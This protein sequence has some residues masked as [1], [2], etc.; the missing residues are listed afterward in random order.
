MFSS[1]AGGSVRHAV[2]GRA[3]SREADERAGFDHR[4]MMREALAFARR[5]P[6]ISIGAVVLFF[7]G[8]SVAAAR[9]YLGPV[10]AQAIAHLQPAPAS[11]TADAANRPA[12][13]HTFARIDPANVDPLYLQMLFAFEDRRFYW[14]FGIDPVGIVRAVRDLVVKQRIVTGGSTL[15]MQVARLIDNDYSRSPRMKLRQI[16]RAIQLEAT[17]SKKEILSLYL[18]LAPF[19]GKVKGVRAATLKFFG[20]EPGRLSTAEAALLVALPQAPE[21]RRV[22]RRAAAARRAR[23]FVLRTVA[24]AGVLTPEEARTAALEPLLAERPPMPVTKPA[25]RPTHTQIAGLFSGLA[26]GM[27]IVA[28]AALAD[29]VQPAVKHDYFLAS[30]D[31]LPLDVRRRL[32]APLPKDTHQDDRDALW[33]F[34]ASRREPVWVERTGWTP[35]ARAMIEEL[36]RADDWGLD[37]GEFQVP[38]LPAAEF[39]RI[40]LSDE[41]LVDA[42]MALSLAALKYAR[43]ARGGRIDDPATQ[44]SS[45]LDRKPQVKSPYLV[46][47][48]LAAAEAP[49]DFLRKMHPQHPQFERLRQRYLAI[50]DGH[51]VEQIE[52]PRGSMI[53]PG[54]THDDIA[55]IRQ[56]LRAPAKHPEDE[57]RYDDKLVEAVKSFQQKRGLRQDGLIGSNTRRAFNE[58]TKVSLP[59]LLANMEQ[60]R[61][62]PEDLGEAYVWVNIP[63]YQVRVVKD[64]DMLHSERVIVGELSKQTPIFSQDM[65][66]IYFHP[67]WN[68]PQSIKI[69]QVLP[70]L[71]RG[72][73]YFYKQGFRLVRNGREIR[74]GSV[75]WS[76]A[77]IRNYDVY[78]PSG[79]YNALG[80][81]KFTFPNKHAVYLHDTQTKGLFTSSQPTFSHGC[82]RVRNPLVLAQLLLNIDKNWSAEEVEQMLK[83]KPDEVAVYLD[84]HIPVHLTYFTAQVD[85]NGDVTTSKDVYGHEKRI[86]QALNGQWKS[87][88]KGADHL[89]QVELA[90]R[91]DNSAK[92]SKSRNR[93]AS[94]KSSGGGAKR[95]ASRRGGGSS[96]NYSRVSG[97][98]NSANDVFRRSFGY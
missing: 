21:A 48:A 56:R 34:Y 62:M 38:E 40:P 93:S 44:L 29:P 16:A 85:E 49:D 60:W 78:Q 46:M 66:R 37:A 1:S 28:P 6:A 26:I 45:Y 7:M 74:P 61:W 89:A 35:G 68:V 8:V 96:G 91:L 64:G 30:D 12:S 82:V 70:S 51:D 83:G 36:G 77:D 95:A 86:T 52:I 67:R 9:L 71:Q 31:N 23:D 87:I 92:Q 53:V 14:H 94:R 22:D 98:G 59:S 54:D 18:A 88:N 13:T 15:T 80:L 76:K 81:M 5:N 73:G 55:L 75:N 72:G 2:F 39:A 84:K 58:G 47:S 33:M 17:L 3:I 90:R 79:R 27:S 41:E 32:L 11:E 24:T 4:E 19:G 63:E 10:P 65:E 50:R 69:K 97:G 20:K 25:T 42:E 57:F 43:F